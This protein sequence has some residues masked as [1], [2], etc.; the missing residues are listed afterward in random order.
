MNLHVF[1][2]PESRR[3]WNRGGEWEAPFKFADDYHVFGLE[4]GPKTIRYFVD[5][6]L[7]RSVKNDAW[8]APMFMLFDVYA[9]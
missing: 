8:H 5:G 3:H 4:W 1:Q 9:F 7:V 6:S 2:T